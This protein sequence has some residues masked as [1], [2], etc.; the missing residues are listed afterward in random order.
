MKIKKLHIKG[1]KNLTDAKLEHDG[2]LIAIIGNNGCGK[3]NLLEAISCIF[4]NLY[5]NEKNIP[6]EFCLEYITSNKNKVKI[7]KEGSKLSFYVDGERSVS[8]EKYLPK[9]TIAIYSG[10]ENRLWNEYYR[11][12]YLDYISN[13]NKQQFANLP[14]MLYLNKY[15]WNI[16]LLCLCLSD[17]NKEFVQNVLGINKIDKIKFEFAKSNYSNYKNSPVLNLIQRIDG[18]SEYMLGGISAILN[19]MYSINNIFSYLYIAFTPDKMKIIKDIT[20]MFNDGLIIEDLSEGQKKLLLLKAA[21]E[22]AGQEDTL[23]LLDEPD[24][25]VHVNNKNKVIEAL[26]PYTHNRQVIVTTHSPTITQCID[27]NN[28]YMMN[29]GKFI[30]KKQQEII[31]EITGEFWN[32]HQQNSFLASKKGIILLVEGK[33]DKEHILNAYS[34]LKDEYSGL[35]FDV[36]PLN[37]ETKIQKFMEG[38]YEVNTFNNKLYIA[39]YDNEK[40]IIDKTFSKG[41]R[42]S[43]FNDDVKKLHTDNK[44][45]HD[46]F[47]AILLPKPSGHTRDCTIENMFDSE[48]YKEAYK[49][50]LEKS[51]NYFANKSISDISEDITGKAKNILM[52]KSKDFGKEDFK[53]F[54]T[55]FDLINQIKND[56]KKVNQQEPTT[57]QIIN[58]PKPEKKEQKD[59]PIIFS[60]KRSD[61]DAKATY[62]FETEEITILSGS[63]IRRFEID[64]FKRNY[65]KHYSQ[66]QKT[67]SKTKKEIKANQYILGE[68]VVISNLRD[69]ILFCTTSNLNMSKHWIDENNKSLEDHIKEHRERKA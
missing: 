67:L 2:D 5:K 66:R 53:N 27:E 59:I 1:H 11:K 13:I 48:K 47:F 64:S 30:P 35:N 58:N 22:F 45:E 68:D 40:E 4:K 41:W 20:V 8:I 34:K 7:E 29:S 32:A 57:Q 54:R 23:Y 65:P 12:F 26:K 14:Q 38:L 10:E 15:Y 25:H 21:L 44:I 3:S 60:L 52:D 24:A 62:N 37:T 17:A 39:I 43:E 51:L 31:E 61:A 69:A 49:E 16:A 50:A 6:F 42:K 56:C 33:H 18:K 28:L 9:K 19:D 46:N 36:F 55:L 63:K